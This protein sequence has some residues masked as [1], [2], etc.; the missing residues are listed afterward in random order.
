M[1]GKLLNREK[2]FDCRKKKL[3]TQFA[4][5]WKEKRKANRT[6]TQNIS[7]DLYSYMVW[8]QMIKTIMRID[9]KEMFNSSND[10]KEPNDIERERERERSV[11]DKKH[12]KT[13]IPKEMKWQKYIYF[14]SEIFKWVIECSN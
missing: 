8:Y 6:N 7:T 1:R 13:K 11:T 12:N 9:L 10:K 3:Q 14:H 5:E 4:L 2:I